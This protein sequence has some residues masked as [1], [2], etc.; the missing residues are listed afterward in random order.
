M[1]KGQVFDL[2]DTLNHKGIKGAVLAADNSL[3]ARSDFF[4]VDNAE[5][6]ETKQPKGC[7]RR[8]RHKQQRDQQTAV[9][10]PVASMGCRH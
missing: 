8:K 10:G 7:Q 3:N 5:P 1:G 4:V 6:V 2:G 9:N